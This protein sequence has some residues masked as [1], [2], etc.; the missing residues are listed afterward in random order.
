MQA[1]C[2]E[3]ACIPDVPLP[4]IS[5]YDYGAYLD[6]REGM[7]QIESRHKKVFPKSWYE[8][9]PDDPNDIA[10]DPNCNL[11]VAESSIPN[12]GLGVFAGI[13]FQVNELVDSNP[14]TIIP[15]IDIDSSNGSN[16]SKSLLSNYPWSSWTQGAHLESKS[17]N[18]LYPNLGMLANS[19]L[20]LSNIYQTEDKGTH[21]EIGSGGG[22]NGD[23]D[24]S[25]EFGTGART[26]YSATTF[27]AV[28]DII[29]GTE[30]FADYG[31]SYFHD[32]EEKF[33]MVFPTFKNYEEADEIVK[34]FVAEYEIKIGENSEELRDAWAHTIAELEEDG[35][36][37]RVAFALPEDVEDLQYV[38]AVGTARYSIPE[39]IRS[40]EWLDENGMCLDNLRKGKS[41]I[42]HAGHGAFAMT[43]FD[44]GDVVA[45]LVLLPVQRGLVERKN[46]PSQLLMNYCIGH[47]DSSLMFFPYS[48]GVQYI[49]HSADANAKIQWSSSLHVHRHDLLEEE[50]ENAKTG[51]IMD[52][53]ALRDIAVGEEVTID[54]GEGWES[55]WF[56]HVNSWE[57][58]ML[59]SESSSV[60]DDDDDDYATLS[61][62]P[63]VVAEQLNNDVVQQHKPIRTVEEQEG[64]PYPNCI[65]TACYSTAYDGTY[66][67]SQTEYI[68]NL[69]YCD[70]ISR[71]RNEGG[72]YYSAKMGTSDFFDEGSNGSDEFI[73]TDVPQ[74][75]IKFV[76]E[77]Y[78]S[79]MHVM[80][81]F[82]HEIHV[83]DGIYPDQWLDLA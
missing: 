38:A 7:P 4:T 13:N 16:Y 56:D 79:D 35:D 40:I 33:Q 6:Q 83:P 12:S 22:N 39:S 23:G 37:V 11:Y 8:H 43:D 34:N 77:E 69:R 62:N 53:V 3:K 15:L 10:T 63:A 2:I 30:I 59:L 65:A 20:G 25:A 48:S 21:I 45:P 46:V 64:W 70:I 26:L 36:K 57:D 47:P 24:R 81:S 68:K 51:L 44:E 32:R 71:E 67:F 29:Q 74:Y 27:T 14:Q 19:H 1:T 31:E 76:V 5:R 61:T 72:Y 78:C 18:I 52:I 82:R 49:N 42:P 60:G 17:S 58:N 75:A 9:D 66:V 80:G 73:V 55:A 50:I 28:K 41:S 54:Y